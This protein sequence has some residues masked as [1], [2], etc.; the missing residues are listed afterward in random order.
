[1]Y[2]KIVLMDERPQSWN[3]LKRM[4]WR[5]W[6]AEVDRIKWLLMAAVPHPA[7]LACKVNIDY[8]VYFAKRPHDADNIPAKLFTDGLIAC[9]LI[10][11]DRRQFVGR[12]STEARI[13]R[14][15][16]GSKLK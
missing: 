5:D 1:M 7:Q 3:R 14:E 8:T 9:G 4:H 15:H 10:A 2:Q 16:P 13:D 11:D 6:Q 12:V